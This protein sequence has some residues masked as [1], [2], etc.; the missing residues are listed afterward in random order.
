MAFLLS[1]DTRPLPIADGTS[2]T[3]APTTTLPEIDLDVTVDPSITPVVASIPAFGGVGDPR[4]VGRTVTEEGLASDFVVGE[5]VIVVPDEEALETL[6]GRDDIEVVDFD[7][8]PEFPE[9]GI[10]VLVRATDLDSIDIATAAWAFETLEPQLSGT[11]R[12]DSEATAATAIVLGRL[13]NDTGFEMS[14]NVV[15]TGHDVDEGQL[16]EA[17]QDQLNA[18]NWP[19]VKSTAN[20][21]IGLD[22]AWQ[23]LDFHGKSQN[24]VTVLVID[25]GFVVNPD[26]PENA[27]IR[28][29]SWGADED[30][31]CTNDT[32][33]PYHG[34]Q[35]ALTIAGLHDNLWGTAG[36]AAPYVHLIVMP[37]QGGTYS[38]MKAARTVIKEENVDIVN[39][40]F[41]TVATTL[42]SGT[43]R[44]YD[45]T[46]R[47]ARRWNETVAFASAGNEGINV[48]ATEGPYLPCASHEIICVGGMGVDTTE[49]HENSNY[50]TN[51]NE[52]SVE[53]YGPYCV[54]GYEDPSKTGS[55]GD[56]RQVC[57]TSYSSPFVAGVAA[58]LRVADPGIT[59]V[60]IEDVLFSTAHEGGLGQLAT[61]YLRRIDA[62]MAVAKA[63]GVV[64]TPPTV[65]V[66][67]E[68]GEFPV[69]EVISLSGSAASY[70]GEPLPL[71]WH[72]NIDGWLN[73]VPSLTPIGA[74]L[75]PGDH[76][77]QATAIDRRNMSGVDSITISIDNEPPIVTILSPNDGATIYEGVAVN[78][79]AYTHD[80][81]IYVNAALPEENVVWRI[82]RKSNGDVI[83]EPSGHSNALGLEAGVYTIE[84][85]GTDIHGT[86]V[87][88]SVEITVI[89]LP[90]GA[91]QPETHIIEPP[92]DIS[93]GVGN[94]GKEVELRAFANGTDGNPVSGTRFKW[95]ATADNGYSFDICTGSAFPGAGGGGGGFVI[96]KDCKETS[97]VFGLA[98]GAVGRT[99]WS[100]RVFWVDSAGVEIDDV[101]EIEVSFAIG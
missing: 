60:E 64:W 92:T 59:A 91:V 76:L 50:G 16:L 13:Y 10:D 83:W 72:S 36:V 57:G 80:P 49:K 93:F 43:R 9:D 75:S 48:D 18:F 25:N 3:A 58:L 51:R 27:R 29:G 22:T 84:L 15:P 40:S 31:V 34:T 61:G 28:A 56:A 46:F 39:M 81:D 65:Q 70:V 30:W 66:H 77:I 73:D 55:N 86:T 38:T 94:T 11:L 6:R 37:T 17:F 45:K 26:F 85:R 14:L 88:D 44:Q 54:Y 89:E 8:D 99:K 62:H 98:P 33:C 78:M 35:V 32:P 52:A 97:A 2:T 20:Q 67:T 95:T 24:R 90:P 4:P 41:G 19:F 101:R 68:S 23:M 87:T 69:D 5:A 7:F 12:V 79:L 74:V 21:E 1:R 96:L 42:I 53:I 82:V 71:R 100:V 47:R 63:L